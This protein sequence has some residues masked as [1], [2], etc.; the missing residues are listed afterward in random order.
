MAR[1]VHDFTPFSSSDCLDPKAS[2]GLI[3]KSVMSALGGESG[4][5]HMLYLLHLGSVKNLVAQD[6][7][8][9]ERSHWLSCNSYSSVP[10]QRLTEPLCCAPCVQ[11]ISSPSA[12]DI[13]RAK[14]KLSLLST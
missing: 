4:V 8:F 6:L 3:G 12:P 1:K 9:H 14:L 2:V 7:C 5:W 11:G 10:T 13:S